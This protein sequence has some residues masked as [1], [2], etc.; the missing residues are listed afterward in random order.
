MSANQS[1]PLVIPVFIPQQGCPHQCVYCDQASIS[2]V[3]DPSWNPNSLREYVQNYLGSSARYPVQVAFYGGTFTRLPEER[4]RLF[5]DCLQEF[6]ELGRIHS[7][8]LSTRPDAI[9]S[10]NLGFLKSMGV[11]TIE[12]GV[13]SLSE[14]VLRAS[15]RGHT[16]ED[17][18]EA[19]ARVKEQGLELGLQ[20]MPGLPRDNKETF[21]RTVEKSISLRPNFI[22]LYPTV[23]LAGTAL[24]RLY[25]LGR[26]RPLSLN[27][28]VDWC[29]EAKVRC[30]GAGISIIRMG[31]QP[32][33]S[34]ERPGAVVAGPYHP[35][36]GQLVKAASWFDRI[37]PVLKKARRYSAHLLIHAA[38]SELSDIRGHRNANIKLWLERLQLA[39][40]KTVPCHHI[41]PGNFKLTVH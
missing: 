19:A 25:R 4:Q 31:L 22:R 28:A 1:K 21:I 39:S 10:N 27:E 15:G 18:Y 13:Q 29:K 41:M 34:L 14:E 24:S 9:K 12:L 37:S 8:R 35:A 23:V 20:L 16:S 7:L 6:L 26:Y 3:S 33:A 30:D 2:G 38:S 5:L 32:T 36:F 11:K 40:L 17:V